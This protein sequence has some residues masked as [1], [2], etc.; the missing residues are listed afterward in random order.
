MRP[1]MIRLSLLTAL[2]VSSTFLGG[3]KWDMLPH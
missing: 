3:W 1:T 2:V